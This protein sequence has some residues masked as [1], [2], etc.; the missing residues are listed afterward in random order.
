[1]VKVFFSILL[2][3][4]IGQLH[5]PLSDPGQLPLFL[6]PLPLSPLL[7]VS[8]LSPLRGTQVDGRACEETPECAELAPASSPRQQSA[9]D[10]AIQ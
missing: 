5:A 9:W 3:L 4:L 6:L 7:S 10:T 1:M 2:L 8:P